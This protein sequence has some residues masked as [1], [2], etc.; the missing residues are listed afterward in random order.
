MSAAYLP[1]PE[2]LSSLE[3]MQRPYLT[4]A[5]SRIRYMTKSCLKQ[6]VDHKRSKEQTA[7]VS[8]NP[9]ALPY[10]DDCPSY[11]AFG[12]RYT[13]DTNGTPRPSQNIF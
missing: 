2:R 11:S 7:L 1:T 4:V 3:E 6:G 8:Q 5:T 13:Q 10:D 12:V 9:I